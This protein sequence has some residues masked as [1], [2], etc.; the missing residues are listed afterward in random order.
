MPGAVV[1]AK[2]FGARDCVA[3]CDTHLLHFK[4]RPFLAEFYAELFRTFPLRDPVYTEF[5]EPYASD[6][7]SVNGA[8]P[9]SLRSYDRGRRFH[10]ALHQEAYEQGRVADRAANQVSFAKGTTE[11]DL[12]EHVGAELRVEPR[13]LIADA[14]FASAVDQLKLHCEE[15]VFSAIFR[16]KKSQTLDAVMKLSRTADSRQRHRIQGV[17]D[18]RFRSLAPQNDDAVFDTVAFAEVPNRLARARGALEKLVS[19]TGKQK[20]ARSTTDVCR[21]VE[22]CQLSARTLRMFLFAESAMELDIP[23]DLLKDKVMSKLKRIDQGDQTGLAKLGLRLTVKSIWDY[24]EM[25]RRELL[26]TQA[27]LEAAFKELDRIESLCTDLR[28]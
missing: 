4:R 28:S 17:L 2:E 15:D 13:Q 7:I 3:Q 24:P 1:T 8:F 5:V 20:K 12:I 14:K 16:P 23:S 10:E 19:L 27:E 9:E 21:L 26:P 22:L 6:P 25:R 18:G 11:R